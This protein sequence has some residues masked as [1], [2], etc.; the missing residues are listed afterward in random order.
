MPKTPQFVLKKAINA[1]RAVTKF[2]FDASLAAI[3][4]QTINIAG[5]SSFDMQV[6]GS[7]DYTDIQKPI[8]SLNANMPKLIYLDYLQ[9]NSLVYFRLKELPAFVVILMNT[10]GIDSNAFLNQWFSYD[11][12]PLPTDA[13]KSLEAQEEKAGKNGSKTNKFVKDF[14]TTLNEPKIRKSIRMKNEKL[15]S[16]SMYHISFTPTDSALDIFW[17]KYLKIQYPVSEQPTQNQASLPQTEISKNISGFKM[18][19]WIDPK[20]Y[21]VHKSTIIFT[22]KAYKGDS[23]GTSETYDPNSMIES[24]IG[25]SSDVNVS[26]VLN[27]S[28][29]GKDVTFVPPE[30]AV[31]IEE[32]M[33]T[34]TLKMATPSAF[35]SDEPVLTPQ[36]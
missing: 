2:S 20:T 22:V 23:D 13:R 19:T 35:P 33:K 7:A 34:I 27:L 36:Y 16:N 4:Q 30:G 32:F 14:F 24:F 9:K 12:K 10:Y 21:L 3:S 26:M 6:K 1:H 15:G 17:E 25:Q 31:N 29:Y 11:V 28:N 8:I 18:E 5:S